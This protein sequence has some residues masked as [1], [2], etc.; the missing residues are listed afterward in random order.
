MFPAAFLVLLVYG[1]Q[2]LA[3]Q[4]VSLAPRRDF[5][6]PETPRSM[7]LVPEDADGPAGSSGPKVQRL[8]CRR[9]API[10]SAID[11]VLPKSRSAF[12]CHGRIRVQCCCWVKMPL[13]G[14]CRTLLFGGSMFSGRCCLRTALGGVFCFRG[15]GGRGFRYM[16]NA[17]ISVFPT[18]SAAPLPCRNPLPLNLP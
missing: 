15:G 10:A 3:W 11:V 16:R 5:P 7:A 9:Y 17:C 6:L 4:A 13:C 2:V 18:T 8:T 1:T 12:L 14:T